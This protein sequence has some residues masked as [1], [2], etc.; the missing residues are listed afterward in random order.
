LPTDF[1]DHFSRIAAQYARFRPRYPEELFEFLAATA[2]RRAVAW[3]CATGSGQAA[4]GLATHFA[5]VIATDA[6]AAQLSRAHTHPRIEYVVAA[7]EQSGLAAKSADLVTAAQALHWLNPDD[8]YAEARRV[9]APDG[10]IAVWTYGNVSLQS[11]D[12][13][14]IVRTFY[15]DIVGPFWPPERRLVETAYRTLPFPFDEIAAPSFVMEAA[16]T[17]GLFTGYLRTWSATVRY[18]ECHNSDPVENVEKQLR[19]I[20]KDDNERHLFRWPLHLR[21]GR[22]GVE[23]NKDS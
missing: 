23:R 7:A 17:L 16:W 8:F 15:H 11:P 12:A 22:N 14:R 5:R 13:E 6:S 9:L 1:K 21:V 10:I 3:D 20:W 4:R 19:E 18:V 2:P